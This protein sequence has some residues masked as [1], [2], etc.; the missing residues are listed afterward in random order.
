VAKLQA[1]SR[2]SPAQLASVP[3]CSVC[4]GRHRGRG[5]PNHAAK[6]DRTYDPAESERNG[7]RC[8][9]ADPVHKVVCYG[10]GHVARHHFAAV[11]GSNSLSAPRG[12]VPTRAGPAGPGRGAPRG[13]PSRGGPKGKGRGGK[14]RRS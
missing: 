1:Q 12:A 9:Y 11:S 13:G 2:A 8:S 5:C 4:R 6:Q 14:G 3:I 10:R 7:T